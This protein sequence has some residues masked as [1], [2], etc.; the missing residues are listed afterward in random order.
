MQAQGGFTMGPS[1]RESALKFTE[2]VRTGWLGS[3]L[4]AW[5]DTHLIRNERLLV[6]EGRLSYVVEREFGTVVIGPMPA[7]GPIRLRTMT[8][9]HIPHLLDVARH[10]V[11]HALRAGLDTGERSF[12][13]QAIYLDRVERVRGA[14]N[15]SF[16]RVKLEEETPLSDMV[17][18]L[19]A[20]DALERPQDYDQDLAVCEACGAVSITPMRPGSRRGCV[21]HP[22]GSADQ[23]HRHRKSAFPAVGT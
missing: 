3:D 14:D 18:A 23:P 7:N 20:A 6:P 1:P 4:I 19:F 5:A 11:L 8:A 15:K 21:V 9:S 10:N 16:W 17:L 12:V 13:H 2:G 22:F